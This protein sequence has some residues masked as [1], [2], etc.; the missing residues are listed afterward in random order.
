M[1]FDT[2]L[3]Y[4]LDFIQ[5]RNCKDGSAHLFSLIYKFYSP[6]THLHYVLTADYHEEDVFAVKFYAQMHRKSGFKY[7]LIVNK[8]DIGNILMTCLKVIPIILKKYPNASFGFIGSRSYDRKSKTLENYEKTQRFRVYKHIVV[9]TIGNE[10]FQHYQYEDLS[11]YLLINRN[12]ELSMAMKER[13]IAKMFATTY[14]NLQD[15]V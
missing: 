4:D 6:I 15:V 11:G 2:Y 10:T 8:G 3:G 1:T 12:N 13:A 9:Q 7:S 5:K 14:N